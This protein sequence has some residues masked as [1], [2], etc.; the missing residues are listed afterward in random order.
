MHGK[1]EGTRNFLNQLSPSG[2]IGKDQDVVDAVLYLTDSTFTSGTVMVVDG[3]S[4]S[5]TW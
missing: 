3:G 2:R 1:D 5:G 4:T